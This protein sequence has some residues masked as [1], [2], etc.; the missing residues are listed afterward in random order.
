MVAVASLNR[1]PVVAQVAEL[2]RNG[3][4]ILRADV[5][6]NESDEWSAKLKG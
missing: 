2:M 6:R 5:E 3:I 4:P 1:D